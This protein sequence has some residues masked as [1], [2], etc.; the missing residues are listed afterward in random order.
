MSASDV[1]L[2]ITGLFGRDDMDL[3]C[4]NAGSGEP[5]L[6]E[7]LGVECST[8]DSGMGDA[9]CELTSGMCRRF[10]R[11][12]KLVAKLLTKGCE[13]VGDDV[14]GTREDVL[15]KGELFSGDR[16]PEETERAAEPII[17]LEAESELK[18]EAS[19]TFKRMSVKQE[20]K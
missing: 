15:P 19:S 8:C 6:M 11:M 17:R 5:I 13:S 4:A 3:C 10:I 16:V 20:R 1:I 2:I 14:P 7:Q 9:L 12:P 18:C